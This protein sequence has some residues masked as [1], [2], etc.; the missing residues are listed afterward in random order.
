MPEMTES[1]LPYYRWYVAEYRGSLRVQS[2]SW[3]ARAIYREVLDEIW[4]SGC[5]SDQLEIIVSVSRI[6]RGTVEKHWP[7]VRG[8]LLPISGPD[9]QL[10]TSERLEAERTKIDKGRVQ[11]VLAGKASAKARHLNPTAVERPFIAV[12]AEKS[13]SMDGRSTPVDTALTLPCPRCGGV[14]EE[15]TPS[16]I[17][18]RI[19]AR[20]DQ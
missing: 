19:A 13:S 4:R 10:L 3:Q 1:A 17:I 12:K 5:I 15:H 16:C 9:A 20:G 7:A 6:P 18:G 8:L 11:R 2:L 14:S